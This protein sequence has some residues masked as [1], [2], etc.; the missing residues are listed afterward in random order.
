MMKY[1]CW[2]LI[3][4]LLPGLAW[5]EPFKCLDEKG[6]VVYSDRPCTGVEVPM[7]DQ[8]TISTVDIPERQFV[9]AY[10]DNSKGGTVSSMGEAAKPA[11][12]GSVSSPSSKTDTTRGPSDKISNRPVRRLPD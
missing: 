2:L 1:M 9:P 6:R 10:Q 5:A 4:L 7:D 3:V 11:G 12:G 8:G